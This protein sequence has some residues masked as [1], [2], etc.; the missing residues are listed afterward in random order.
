MTFGVNVLA[1]FH[2]TMSLLPALLAADTPARV[3]NLSSLAHKLAP[4]GGI[5]FE[6]L[7]GP[8]KGRW[9]PPLAL[10]ERYKYYGEVILR[11]LAA[12]L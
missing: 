2:L 9:F 4:A 1:H 11:H 8:K 3:V 6:H 7:K 5:T 10:N 12:L